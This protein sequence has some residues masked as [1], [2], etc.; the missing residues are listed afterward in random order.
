MEIS[1]KAAKA[2]RNNQDKSSEFGVFLLFLCA[3]AA[4]RDTKDQRSASFL[5]AFN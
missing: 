2:Q 4:L 1:R 3:V 5:P